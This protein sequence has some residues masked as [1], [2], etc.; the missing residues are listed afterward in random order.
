[1]YPWNNWVYE[2]LLKTSPML[3]LQGGFGAK[4]V[5]KNKKNGTTKNQIKSGFESEHEPNETI[6][7]S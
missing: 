7:N 1:M 6:T 3:R 5:K 2:F 4:M